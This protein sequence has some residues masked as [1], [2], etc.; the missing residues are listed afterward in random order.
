MA[1]KRHKGNLIGVLLG[2]C[3]SFYTKSLMEGMIQASRDIGD[4]SISLFGGMHN[5]F[6]MD[7]KL[8]KTQIA[9]YTYQFNTIYEYEKIME[10]DALIISYGTMLVY[11]SEERDSFL[12]RFNHIPRLLLETPIE[13]ENCIVSQNKSGQAMIMEHLIVEHGYERIAYITGPEGCNDSNER[14][15]AYNEAMNAHGL[16]YDETYVKHG[17]HTDNVDELVEDLLDEHPDIQAIVCSNDSE[18][19]GVYRVLERLGYVVGR[20]I[21]V[22]GFDD[23]DPS[24]TVTPALTTVGQHA[25]DIGYMAIEKIMAILE[26]ESLGISRTPNH[27]LVRESCGCKGDRMIGMF[28]N[29]SLEELYDNITEY[30]NRCVDYYLINNRNQSARK[31]CLEI[32]IELLSTVLKK[33]M[34][35]NAGIETTIDVNMVKESFRMLTAGKYSRLVN[36]IT[37]A[38]MATEYFTS[39]LKLVKSEKLVQNIISIIIGLQQTILAFSVSRKDS[40]YLDVSNRYITSPIF[41]KDFIEYN[42]DDTKHVFG[43]A[44]KKLKEAGV[45]NAYIL[46]NEE[47]VTINISKV[48]PC[49]KTMKLA[50]YIM[51]STIKTFNDDEMP[52]IGNEHSMREYLQSSNGICYF[53]FVLFSGKTQYGILSAEIDA[54]SFMT[55]NVISQQLS[56][57]LRY[58]QLG[59]KERESTEELSMMLETIRE[60]NDILLF[61]SANDELTGLYNRRGFM[62]HAI[63]KNKSNIGKKAYFIF[64]DLDHLK[65]INDSFGH[66]EGDFAIQFIAD[67][68]RENLDP[69][70]IVGRIGG[71]EF[72]AMATSDN[73]NFIEDF[74]DQITKY[75]KRMNRTLDKPYFIECSIGCTEVVCQESL[76]LTDILRE[77]DQSLY[78]EK[79]KRRKTIKK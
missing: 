68:F 29:L 52:I 50:A 15:S 3:Y 5:E 64:A 22:T 20:D 40:R 12:S 37:V 8:T 9:D 35:S 69:E 2:D 36:E 18:A 30:A 60:K 21:A 39:I 14:F 70:D 45:K 44:I 27:L 4:M 34:D 19:L 17:N 49:P 67:M 11:L 13:G 54:D 78:E 26:G 74:R 73:E 53:S 10:C 41:I 7:T 59:R 46:L 77:T 38:K 32:Q 23:A 47:P 75:L 48:F 72:V 57:V 25:F 16:F 62:E 42:D 31:F 28:N 79:K 76:N 61:I 58:L 33:I 63:E 51:G 56:I 55:L 71:D 43:M 6:F 66:S 1:E 65:E 24:K